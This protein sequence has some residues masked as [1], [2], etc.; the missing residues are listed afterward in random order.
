M[1]DTKKSDYKNLEKYSIHYDSNLAYRLLKKLRKK[2]RNKIWLL[3]KLIGL[4]VST[5]GHLLSALENPETPKRYKA[6][7]IGAIGYI[8]FPVD[9]IPDVIPLIGYGDDVMA[10]GGILALVIA[11]STFSLKDLDVEIDKDGEKPV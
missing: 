4:I 6:A 2:T 1:S 3:S 10:T 5:L 7:I 9:V 8:I 11:Y